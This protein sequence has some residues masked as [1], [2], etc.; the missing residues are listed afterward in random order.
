MSKLSNHM[1]PSMK[2]WSEA[3]QV[4]L[5]ATSSVVGSIKEVKMLG[6]ISMW[7]K[8]VQALRVAELERSSQYR[9]LITYL[10]ILGKLLQG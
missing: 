4:R 8:T 2:K 6:Q 10:N 7:T 5:T 9:V 1:G 3:V